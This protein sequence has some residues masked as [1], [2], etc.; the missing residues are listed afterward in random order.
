MH[1]KSSNVNSKTKKTK[2]AISRK[3]ELKRNV[4]D[5]GSYQKRDKERTTLN[6]LNRKQ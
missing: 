3:R 6:K 5:N 2:N 1:S 4:I